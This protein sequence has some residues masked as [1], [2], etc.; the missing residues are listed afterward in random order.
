MSGYNDLSTVL[1]WGLPP[2]DTS[3]EALPVFNIDMLPR[4]EFVLPP[5]GVVLTYDAAT[6]SSIAAAAA[7][8]ASIVEAG[9]KA[10]EEMRK[11]FAA[12]VAS[13]PSLSIAAS[14]ASIVEA[15]N[16]VMEE[17][18]KQWLL[19]A[20]AAVKD[21]NQLT[22]LLESDPLVKKALA[23]TNN[24]SGET[25]FRDVAAQQFG[26]RQEKSDMPKNTLEITNG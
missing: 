18:K 20:A 11:R 5:M 14:S 22:S 9:N 1:E 21:V 4:P 7:C 19:D 25:P 12:D 6:S 16:K 3:P 8:S 2:F 23:T 26:A 24:F 17:M 13:L 15:G 10:L